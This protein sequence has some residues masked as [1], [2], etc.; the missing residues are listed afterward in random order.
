MGLSLIHPD[1][2]YWQGSAAE[3]L[4]TRAGVTLTEADWQLG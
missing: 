4:A 2:N 3:L 1:R